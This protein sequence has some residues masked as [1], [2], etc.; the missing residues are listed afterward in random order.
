MAIALGD[1]NADGV[2]DL[3]T[4]DT[5]GA[6]RR[7]SIV[8]GRLERG[9][10][11]PRGPNRAPAIASGCGA[12]VS[13]PI[14]T[15]TA[16]SMSWRRAPRAPA[17]GWRA[18]TTRSQRLAGAVDAEIW[19]VIDLDGDGQL[20]LVG[21]VGGRPVRFTGRG[22][23]GYHHQVV[24]PRAQTAAGD[25]RVNSF[26]IGGE[27]EVRSGRLVQKQTITGTVRARRARARARAST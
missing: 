4:L 9:R 25:Q 2:L 16:R 19:S 12:A 26:G 1:V 7:A 23:R 15:T 6:I 11:S 27:V 10:R 13:S 8:A 21:L 24:R 14:S 22:T 17:S 18:R 3:V 5:S 20:D